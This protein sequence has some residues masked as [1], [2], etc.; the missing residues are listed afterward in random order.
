[1]T[2]QIAGGNP[3][4]INEVGL[5][6]AV[7]AHVLPRTPQQEHFMNTSAFASFSEDRDVALRYARGREARRL[8]PWSTWEEDAVVFEMDVHERTPEGPGIYVLKYPCDDDL[9]R[10]DDAERAEIYRDGL[11]GGCEF[12]LDGKRPHTLLL[13][14]V[15]ERLLAE[16]R[17]S[18][19]P[20]A[21]ENAQRDREWLLLPM[22]H[23]ERLKGDASN[24][25][26]SRI[27]RYEVFKFE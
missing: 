6:A 7:R 26:V 9:R 16:P 25:P 8:K 10:P 5:L 27:W 15:A 19:D 17:A 11:P 2:K 23:I 20:K 21:L 14:N 24:I 4:Y 3:A 12:C 22:D 18:R 1:V 13:V